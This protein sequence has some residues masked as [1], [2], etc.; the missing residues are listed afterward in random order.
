MTTINL[1]ESVGS[2][3]PTTSPSIEKWKGM[4]VQTRAHS[5]RDWSVI[6]TF[7]WGR[8]YEF[9][10]VV[11]PTVVAPR[12]SNLKRHYDFYIITLPQQNIWQEVE[13][14]IF[15]AFILECNQRL[16]R[17]VR[18]KTFN[19]NALKHSETSPRRIEGL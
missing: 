6:V 12:L 8:K 16:Q 10:A 1:S 13:I 18:G 14:P 17:S 19:R 4:T 2:A 7:R 5:R 9:Q 15:A 3:A 11:S